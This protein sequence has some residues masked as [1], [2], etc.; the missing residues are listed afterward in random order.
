MVADKSDMKKTKAPTLENGGHLQQVFESS[1]DAMLI[2]D[3]DGKILEVNPATC[4]IYGYS[5]EELRGLS[6]TDLIHPD[7]QRFFATAAERVAKGQTYSAESVNVG[8]DGATIDV[9]VCLT[10]LAHR[11]KPAI[12]AAIRDITEH[13]QME[14]WLR[15]SETRFRQLFDH[16][17]S[18]VA[19]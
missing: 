17:S 5:E 10:P 16:M 6:A 19:V 11:D 12:L 15:E 13:K 3:F 14:Q 1:A 18:G 2:I 7:K 4:T 8:K 9:E